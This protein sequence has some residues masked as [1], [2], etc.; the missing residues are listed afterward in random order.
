MSDT[1]ELRDHSEPCEHYPPPEGHEGTAPLTWQDD[2]IWRCE[3]CPGG[4]K[5]VLRR[6]TAC[7]LYE[8]EGLRA[9]DVWLEEA[10]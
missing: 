1:W 3:W 8:N 2:G 4:K 9:A 6:S 7:D 5:V 10:T